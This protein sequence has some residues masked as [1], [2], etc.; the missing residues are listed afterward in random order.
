MLVQLVIRKEIVQLQVLSSKG[1]EGVVY[2]MN[3][4]V[5]NAVRLLRVV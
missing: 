1:L 3:V 4:G 2:V 5:S